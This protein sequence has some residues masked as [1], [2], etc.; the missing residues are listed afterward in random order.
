MIK[1]NAD[2]NHVIATANAGHSFLL[3][4]NAGTGKSYVT[5]KLVENLRE[6]GSKVIVCSATG[7]SCTPLLDVGA[8]TVHKVFGLKDGRYEPEQLKTLFSDESDDYYAPRKAR[9]R[10]SHVIVIDEIS[11]I[12]V[13]TLTLIDSVCSF[14]KTDGE[15]KPMGGLQCIFVG[16]FLQ[17]PPVPSE[18]TRDKGVPC[19]K[20]ASYRAMV[21]HTVRLVEVLTRFGT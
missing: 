14:C 18:I 15:D 7:I 16:D 21:P 17:L 12:S 8:Q 4:G 11:M 19:F 13:R 10:D 5:L 3:T 1:L 2:Q 6:N 20:H 9:I